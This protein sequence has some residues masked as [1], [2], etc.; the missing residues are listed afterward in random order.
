[1]DDEAL[2]AEIAQVN[3][4]CAGTAKH[5]IAF[6]RQRNVRIVCKTPYA[7]AQI[8]QA[9]PVHI[10]D[11]GH[12]FAGDRVR[13]G[14]ADHKALSAQVRRIDGAERRPT[15]DHHRRA[16]IVASAVGCA[17]KQVGPAVAIDVT[18][19]GHAAACKTTQVQALNDKALRAQVARQ[20][21]RC[22]A[23]SAVHHIALAGFRLIREPRCAN[24]QIVQTVAIDVAAAADSPA[25]EVAAGNPIDDEAAASQA[26]KIN[27]SGTG[28][29]EHHVAAPRAISGILRAHND[30]GQS[31]AVDVARCSHAQPCRGPSASADQDPSIEGVGQVQTLQRWPSQNDVHQTKPMAWTGNQ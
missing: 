23:R 21:D 31:V 22:G 4:R 13:R 25:A 20:L 5:H 18:G 1:M 8:S 10:P 28:T 14:A 29:A 2:R 6:G 15:K 24:N 7:Y 16:R 27:G 9:V 3:V 17:D 19:D 11:A 30:I 26:G 12:R